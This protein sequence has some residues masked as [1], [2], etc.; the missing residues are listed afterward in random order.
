ME[1]IKDFFAFLLN[2]IKDKYFWINMAAALAVVIVSLIIFIFSL[3]II[4]KYGQSSVVPN[5]VNKH[6]LEGISMIEKENLTYKVIDSVY[7]D[8]LPSGTIIEM[9]PSPGLTV[10]KGREITL[11]VSSS[12]APLVEMPALT[13]RSSFRFAQ[14]ELDSRGL[15]LGNVQYVPSPEK[16]AVL[17]QKIG[18]T[19][20][21]PGTM[22]P[23]GTPINLVLG[24]GLQNLLIDAPNF[25]GMR[26]IDVQQIA[27]AQKMPLSI[28]MDPNV[29]DSLQGFV[30]RQFPVPYEEQYNI[31]ETIDVFISVQ[32][33]SNIPTPESVKEKNELKT[34]EKNKP[35]GN[36]GE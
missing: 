6:I 2:L 8:N 23:K 16:D 24:D 14:I 4:T 25:I 19:P 1:R 29:K 11:V 12:Q 3:K 26:L 31:G 5:L 17:E 36:L 33:P 10:K 20:I 21:K 34:I 27:L 35:N 15:K 18:N 7:R 28:H 32:K 22:I 13:G 9:N 30:Y